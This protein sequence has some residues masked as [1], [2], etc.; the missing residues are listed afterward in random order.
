MLLDVQMG[1]LI[2]P[3]EKEINNYNNIYH[4]VV[5]LHSKKMQNFIFKEML[6]FF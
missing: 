4:D 6:Q 5:K 3:Q 2:V 1:S